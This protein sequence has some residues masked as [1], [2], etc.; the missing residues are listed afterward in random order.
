M[1]LPLPLLQVRAGA[2]PFFLFV[3]RGEPILTL[4]ATVGSNPVF[5]IT[6][7]SSR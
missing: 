7:T 5:A 4:F 6:I 3:R 2:L 1:R